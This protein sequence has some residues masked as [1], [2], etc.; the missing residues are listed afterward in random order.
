MASDNRRFP[1]DSPIDDRRQRRLGLLE[2]N[3]PHFAVSHMTTV[4]IWLARAPE[5]NPQREPRAVMDRGVDVAGGDGI[6]DPEQQMRCR[7]AKSA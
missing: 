7:A 1:G 4:V 6:T 2:L 5:S 3:F